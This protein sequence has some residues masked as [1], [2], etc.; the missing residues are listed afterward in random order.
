MIVPN[1]LPQS[2]GFK[3]GDT[4]IVVCAA[5]K[6]AIAYDFGGNQIWELPC[7]A[8][9]QHPNWRTTGGDT[10]PGLYRLGT[11]YL[12]YERWEHE[13]GFPPFCRELRSYGWASFDMEDLEG[14]ED[15]N[16]RAGVMLHGGGSAEG[17]PGAWARFQPLH[18]TLGCLRM[19]NW[20]L[21]FK[22][23]PLYRQGDVFISVSQ[24]EV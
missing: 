10:P 24:D 12:D 18:P 6:T 19:H 22:V 13:P 11:A 23:L 17:W 5:R 1:Q 2:H 14:N 9:G 3:E 4:H 15:G 16:Y 8:D 21:Q 20:D 7:L